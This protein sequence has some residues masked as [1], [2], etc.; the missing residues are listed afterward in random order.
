MRCL[1]IILASL[2]CLGMLA[3]VPTEE[4]EMEVESLA[5]SADE[6]NT[7]LFQLAEEL[8]ILRQNPVEINFATAEELLKIPYLNIFQAGNIIL[9]RKN[10]GS[11]Y[12]PYELMAVK[13]FDRPLIK[14]ITP[15]ISFATERAIPDIDLKNM[16]RYGRHN[17]AF[18]WQRILQERK[19]NTEAA[20][21]PYLGSPN[22]LLGRYRYQYR[23]L[24]SAGL[25]FQHDAGEPLGT[26]LQ[27][28][29]FDHL[30]GNISLRN[31]GNL[32]TLIVG[33]FQAEFGQGLALWSGLAFGKSAA[34]AEI[35]RYPRGF[36]PFSGSEEN[37]FFRGA[38]CSYQIFE[39]L[40]VSTFYSNH[41]QDSRLEVGD[42]LLLSE[43]ATSLQSSGLHRTASELESKH[44]NRL[45]VL[46]GNINY[47]AEGLSAGFTA[48]NYKLEKPLQPSDQLFRQFSF[49]GDNLSNYS[50]DFNYLYKDLNLF[51][52][53]A[54]N[55]LNSSAYTVGLQTN[56][57]DGVYLSLLR[58]DFS[59]NYK[60][61]YSAAFAENGNYGESGNY[62]GL[63][64]EMSAT[65]KLQSYVDLYRFKWARFRVDGPSD[66]AELFTQLEAY[67]SRNFS[68]YIRY[69]NE[70]DDYNNG[71]NLTVQKLAERLRENF[72]VHLAYRLSRNTSADTRLEWS[73][74]KLGDQRE[75]GFMVFQDL[76]YRFPKFRVKSRIALTDVSDYAVRIY[77]YE[78]DLLYAFSI[79][80]Y[81]GQ[82]ARFY[83]FATYAF[84]EKMDLQAR[85]AAT[86]F[87]DR[88]KIS[89]GNQ[90]IDGN[91]ISEIKLQLLLKL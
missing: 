74:Y 79:P 26:E 65:L 51:G 17:M 38:A 45:Q 7:D 32:N 77:A 60:S 12:S 87:F 59:K 72:R 18:R 2:L 4:L 46:G 70:K 69:R 35:K 31:Y 44:S 67:F 37:R 8:A 23:N 56:P 73:R 25:T 36:R 84:G 14:R 42:T 33:D 6:N 55:D 16:A 10:A 41:R 15:Y 27:D 64:W 76:E 78:A 48:V 1:L 39:N 75:N 13:G 40:E 61:I 66:G 43:F 9:F 62:L 82:S 24:I 89:S 57:A 22:A 28:H 85:Y 88:E 5:E 53:F 58:R 29:Y 90:E 30:S 81:Y 63:N 3:Q 21:S 20:T 19:G 80:A 11:I 54:T 50:V 86:R 34:A 47:R 91:V 52:E 49:S 71:E 83:L 68:G